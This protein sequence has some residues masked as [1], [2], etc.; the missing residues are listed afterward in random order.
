MT[1]TEVYLIL[2]NSHRKG[3]GILHQPENT[4]RSHL[5]T[6][7]IRMINLNVKSVLLNRAETWRTPKTTIKIIQ[8][9]INSC[10]RRIFKIHRLE[11]VSNT[12]LW[13]NMHT[14]RTSRKQP[15]SAGHLQK[16]HIFNQFLVHYPFF[17]F[18]F[19]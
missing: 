3:K 10:L 5:I 9:F 7:K 18:F 19:G 15:S 13:E 1:K 6:T 11:A 2:E 4:W 17:F 14:Q 12:K 16:K 8:T